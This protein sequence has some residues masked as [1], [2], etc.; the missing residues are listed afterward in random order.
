[1]QGPEEN[2]Q[3]GF[4]KNANVS[5]AQEF[6]EFLKTNKMWWMTPIILVALVLAG[7]VVLGS[8]SAA[9]FIYTLF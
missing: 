3:K 7:V 5:L 4:E 8:T 1:M 2:A 9:P 6:F